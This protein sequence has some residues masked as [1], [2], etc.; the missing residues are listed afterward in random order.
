MKPV[1]SPSRQQGRR[2][3]E[4]RDLSGAWLISFTDLMALMVTFFVLLFA[5][6]HPREQEWQGFSETMQT[7]FNRFYGDGLG[8]GPEDTISI[9]RIDYNQALDLSYLK[10][11]MESLLAEQPALASI[12][13]SEQPDS[14]VLS[15]PGDA[16]FEPGRAEV[17][18]EGDKMVYALAMTLRRLKNR[19][20]IVGN[21]P[22]I[23]ATNPAFASNWELSLARAAAVSGAIQTVGYDRP[24]RIRGAGAGKYQVADPSLPAAERD[25]AGSRVD[26]VIMEDDGKQVTLFEIDAP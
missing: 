14:L 11:L 8:R 21:A 22:P 6:T 20:E 13:L 19:I 5:M 23:T 16:L 1:Y 4:T 25:A 7:N 9:D 2:L 3:G 12:I 18:G 24:I 10:A 17:K 26:I 15:L